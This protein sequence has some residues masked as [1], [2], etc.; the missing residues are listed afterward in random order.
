MKNWREYNGHIPE[1]IGYRNKFDNTIYTFDIETTSF[2]LLDGEQLS[3]DKYDTLSDDE[4]ERSIPMSNMYIWMLGI[5]DV[6]YYGRTW[7]ELEYFFQNIEYYGTTNKKYI[8]VHNLSYEFQFLRNHFKMKDIFSRKSRK[9]MKCKLEDFNFELRCSYYMSA[10]SLDKL[11][12][13]YNL[14][15]KKLTGN[16]DYN[17]Q[18]NSQTTLTKEELDYCEND[19]LV[20]YEYIQKEL[21]TYKTLKNIPLTSTGHVRRELKEKIDKDYRYKSYVKNSINIDP[22][23][24]NLLLYAFAG[25]YTHSN[26]TLT[27][28]IIKDVDSFDFT[29][30]YPYCMVSYKYPRN[31]I[32]KMQSNKKRGFN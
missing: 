12:K 11:S 6:V 25:G 23:I 2:L 5:N 17:I 15:T 7:K 9:V 16:L 24:Y 3:A 14:K 27:D 10:V 29:S 1:I 20:V 8:Y 4:K 22:H 21:E 32:Q 19:C 30:S 31:S 18:R 28:Q 26:W 13:I